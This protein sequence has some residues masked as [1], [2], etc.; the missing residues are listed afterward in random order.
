MNGVRF[1]AVALAAVGLL[2]WNTRTTGATEYHVQWAT[3][4]PST[5]SGSIPEAAFLAPDIDHGVSWRSIAA[6][7]GATIY[8]D[9]SKPM[10][11]LHIK[12][13]NEGDKF[14]VDPP[15]ASGTLFRK[16]W[17]SPDGREVIYN[18]GLVDSR[19]TCYSKVFPE[20][21]NQGTAR[22]FLGRV[23]DEPIQ[24]PTAEKWRLIYD[25]FG[26]DQEPVLRRLLAVCPSRY[27]SLDAYGVS[28]DGKMVCFVS[29]GRVFLYEDE[30]KT[31]RSVLTDVFRTPINRISEEKAGQG[32]L[33]VL[34][35]SGVRELTVELSKSKLGA[36]IGGS[37]KD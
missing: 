21:P 6:S 5:T 13:K 30:R 1:V 32:S 19:D 26:A 35:K 2:L 23:S 17:Q 34:W 16:V 18:D 25:E 28:Q 27:A 7:G 37:K 10:R 15:P 33:F 20:T 4:G 3:D 8:N 11:A 12:T 29:R 31:L 22:V 9:T 14:I 36:P 24:V